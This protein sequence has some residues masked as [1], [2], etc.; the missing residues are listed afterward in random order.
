MVGAHPYL[1]LCIFYPNDIKVT[2]SKR[3]K[4]GS[5]I[6]FLRSPLK[7]KILVVVVLEMEIVSQIV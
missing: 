2:Q 1:S 3:E 5:C 4:K 6:A 7:K